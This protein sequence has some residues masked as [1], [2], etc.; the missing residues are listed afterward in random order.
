MVQYKQEHSKKK[1]TLTYIEHHFHHNR[2][3]LLKD[4]YMVHY[5]NIFGKT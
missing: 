1:T 2:Q 4:L 3:A 5:T